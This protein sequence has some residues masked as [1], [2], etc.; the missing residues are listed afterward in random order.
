[1]DDERLLEYKVHT[2][3][4]ANAV[5]KLHKGKGDDNVGFYSDN[6]IHASPKLY[7]MLAMLINGMVLYGYSPTHLLNSTIVLPSLTTP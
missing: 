4:I 3:D 6:I 1:M 5:N 2:C 7:A